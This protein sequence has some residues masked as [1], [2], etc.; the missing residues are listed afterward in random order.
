MDKIFSILVAFAIVCY[1]VPAIAIAVVVMVVASFLIWGIILFVK[2]FKKSRDTRLAKE[3]FYKKLCERF[4][5][6]FSDSKEDIE[7]KISN[8]L[9]AEVFSQH[10][11]NDDLTKSFK[12]MSSIVNDAFTRSSI[13]LSQDFKKS[14]F[15]QSAD[16][17]I[18]LDTSF[19]CD[20]FMRLKELGEVPTFCL[21]CD[22]IEVHFF[23]SMCI[24][25]L[26]NDYDIIDV[27][28][29]NLDDLGSFTIEE[30]CAE[31]VRGNT[32]MYHNYLHQRVDGGPD[33]R[34][35]YNPSFPVYRYGGFSMTCQKPYTFIIANGAIV[36]GIINAFTDYKKAYNAYLSNS[37]Y[38]IKQYNVSNDEYASLIHQLLSDNGKDFIK[39]KKFIAMLSDYKVFKEKPYLKQVL[40]E[41]IN[42]SLCD[43]ILDTKCTFKLLNQIKDKLVSSNICKDS[44]ATESFAY[45]A[46]GLEIKS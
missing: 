37:Y 6:D 40:S 26:G 20:G 3:S 1:L 35:S 29:L 46:Y 5:Q 22:N 4:S 32:P 7:L 33:R 19:N 42:G 36:P 27:N 14:N 15:I 41:L 25:K 12:N 24:L 13:W 30:N 10:K 8:I 17:F 43:D 18:R 45:I 23:P 2:D 16:S 39:S 28:D 11:P 38:D 31:I 9:W 34:Y 21:K 44:E